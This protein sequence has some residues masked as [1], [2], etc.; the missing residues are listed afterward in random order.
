MGYYA[1][2]LDSD[3]TV[4][5]ANIPAALAAVQAVGG[6]GADLPDAVA[7][8]TGFQDCDEDGAGFIL[9]HHSEKF[10][11]RTEEVLAALAPFAKEGSFVRFMG[12]DDS[13]FGFRVMN[14]KLRDEVGG[15]SWELAR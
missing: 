2:S 12:E 10:H 5:A 11:S 4:P 7:S 13:M 9:G 1:N 6:E 3:F 8:I 14:G 15:V